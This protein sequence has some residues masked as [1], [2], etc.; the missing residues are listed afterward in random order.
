MIVTR[1]LGQPGIGAI[2]A[3]GLGMAVTSTIVAVSGYACLAITSMIALLT[4]SGC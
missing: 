2:C 4:V 1:G 3:Y